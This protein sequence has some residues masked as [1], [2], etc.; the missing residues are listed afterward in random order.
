MAYETEIAT[1]AAKYGLTPDLVMADVKHESDSDPFAIGDGGMA[2]GLMQ[3][4]PGAAEDVG[5]DWHGL[6]AAI[7]AKDE[8]T[9]VSMGLDIG[10]A[11]LAKM[12]RLFANDQKLAL[13]AYN[14]GPTVISRANA[15][16]TSVL[17]LIP[18]S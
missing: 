12:M 4:H 10:V 8:A 18:S 2:L 1:A 17:T 3:V 15:Y 5:G 14:Q 11:Y 6:L 16:A 7:N 13:M 9:A